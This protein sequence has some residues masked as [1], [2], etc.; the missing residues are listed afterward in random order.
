MTR[1]KKKGKK[2]WSTNQNTKN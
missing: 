2:Q 1:R